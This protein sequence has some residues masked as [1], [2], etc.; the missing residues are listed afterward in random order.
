METKDELIKALDEYIELLGDE[1]NELA[2]L[3]HVH[4]WR[5][6]RAEQGKDLRKK[7]KNLRT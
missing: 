6:G 7:I 5:S 3:A 2:G 1:L 4:G